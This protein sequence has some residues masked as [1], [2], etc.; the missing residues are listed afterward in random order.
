MHD[1]IACGLPIRSLNYL[2]EQGWVGLMM[3]LFLSARAAVNSLLTEASA[4]YYFPFFYSPLFS[5]GIHS[6]I[7]LESRLVP[8]IARQEAAGRPL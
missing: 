8:W 6:T 1:H 3:N 4:V 2:V 7:S 5:L